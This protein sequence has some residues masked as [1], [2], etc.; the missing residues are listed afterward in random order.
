MLCDF[1]RIDAL[2]RDELSPED[3]A[4]VLT[5]MNDC[6]ACRAY[7]EAMAALEGNESVPEGFSARVMDAVR[8]TP[9]EKPRRKRSFYRGALTAAACAVLVL[10]ISLWSGMF[11]G[12]E[13]AAPESDNASSA[14]LARDLDD[15]TGGSPISSCANSGDMASDLPLT[16]HVLT[17]DALCAQVRA[18]LQAEGIEQLY[19]DTQREAYDLTAQQI[20]ALN[21]AF[22]DAVLPQQSLLQLELKS[23]G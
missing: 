10:G 4:A 20:E 9:Q 18:W 22:P 12:A 13:T 3:R 8:Q 23:A 1:D 14:D 11:P 2:C 16:V 17:D 7:Y 6:P 15:A 5:H 19:P 21:K